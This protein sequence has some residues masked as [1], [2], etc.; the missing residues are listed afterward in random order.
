MTKSVHYMRLYAL[1]AMG[2]PWGQIA[3]W[4]CLVSQK[5]ADISMCKDV[6]VM[7]QSIWRGVLSGCARNDPTFAVSA[8]G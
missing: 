5:I 1:H 4:E 3:F 7:H 2:F 8:P 6:L